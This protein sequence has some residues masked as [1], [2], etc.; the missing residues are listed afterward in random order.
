MAD[1]FDVIAGSY[2]RPNDPPETGLEQMPRT[3][4][5]IA[6]WPALCAQ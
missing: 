1:I 2:R 3:L 4:A 5:Q 6:L